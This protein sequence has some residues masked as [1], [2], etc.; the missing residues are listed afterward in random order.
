MYRGIYSKVNNFYKMMHMIPVCVIKENVFTN[1][2]PIY[3]MSAIL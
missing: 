3:L 1:I 2:S